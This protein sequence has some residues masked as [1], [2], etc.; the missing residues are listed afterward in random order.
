MSSWKVSRSWEEVA[1]LFTSTG[2]IPGDWERTRRSASAHIPTSSSL[3]VCSPIFLNKRLLT[4]IT[5]PNSAT[6]H[7][8]NVIWIEN[9]VNHALRVIKPLLEGQASVVE[10][11]PEAE[12]AWIDKTQQKLHEM[13]WSSTQ[14]QSWYNK[15]LD[16]PVEVAGK[17][18][19]RWNGMLYPWSSGHF[20]WTSL[21]PTR[22]DWVYRVS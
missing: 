5:G 20:W 4:P 2:R 9:A 19:Q 22:A 18:T 21:F 12:K 10:V 13:I 15:E 17:K 16:A 6:A 7:T 11:K 3:S 8:S 14:C 1:R